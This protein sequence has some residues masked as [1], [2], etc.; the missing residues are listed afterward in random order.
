MVYV[1]Q[2][3]FQDDQGRQFFTNGMRGKHHL[4]MF[5]WQ[6]QQYM[7]TMR[8]LYSHPKRFLQPIGVVRN[9]QMENAIRAQGVESYHFDM[10]E[11]ADIDEQIYGQSE[12]QLTPE[13]HELVG[14]FID[15]LM[16]LSTLPPPLP[17]PR[18]PTP[19]EL[20]NGKSVPW[21]EIF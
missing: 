21:G 1:F 6:V 16:R 15:R 8:N 12:P 7:E 14:K 18:I 19:S 4:D 11:E 17:K 3:I 13:M 2:I 5:G 9:I 20:M 10:W